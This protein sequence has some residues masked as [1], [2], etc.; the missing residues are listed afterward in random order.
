MEKV[1]VW[2]VRGCGAVGSFLAGLLG[3]W[4]A[5]LIALLLV[6]AL[7]FATGLL[8]AWNGNSSKTETGGLSSS[9]SFKGLTKKIAILLL[10]ALAAVLD[11]AVGTPGV[12]RLAVSMFYTANEGLSILEN[13]ALLGLKLP[14]TL[15]SAL[16]AMRERG[17]AAKND[18]VTDQQG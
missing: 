17:E 13:V 10:I 1:W 12:L 5:T 16:E 3:G 18:D 14:V 7:D 9:V 4:D 15:V 6:M 2:I 11:R 8:V